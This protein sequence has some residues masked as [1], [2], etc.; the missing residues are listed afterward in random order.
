MWS[1]IKKLFAAEPAPSKKPEV[2]SEPWREINW[3]NNG[4]DLEF[5]KN[6]EPS[7]EGQV[8]RIFL[9]GPPGAGKS[10]F[11]NS[12]QS[13]L[14]GRIYRQ[15]LAN[16]TNDG[17]FTKKHTTYK[18]QK[19]NE[20]Y[21]FVFHD[22]MGLHISTG[23]LVEDIRLALKGHVKEGYRFNPES[24]LSEDDQYYNKS[25]KLNDTVHVLV[26]V[27]PADTLAIMYDEV[28]KKIKSVRKDASM[29]DM[30][31]V[32]ILTKID[33]ICPEMKEDIKNVY[34]VLDLKEK[35]EKFSA[36][37]GIPMNCIFP[38]K[39]YHEEI[40]MN[41]DMDSLILSAMKN[42]LDCGNDFYKTHFQS[43]SS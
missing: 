13:V 27:I 35:M 20:T 37:V 31:Q 17:C 18:I 23:V 38:V 11:I 32:A 7:T 12:V 25:P 19:D 3:G 33:L 2:L 28:I 1:R 34:K 4:D 10:S 30:P 21:P 15:A 42:I 8:V 39:N 26:C 14:H 36:A 43:E 40:D 5:V 6:Y 9:H 16:N 41:E 24:S 22:I 29:L